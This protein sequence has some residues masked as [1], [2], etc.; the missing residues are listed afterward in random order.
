MEEATGA[1]RDLL[2][3]FLKRVQQTEPLGGIAKIEP[4][5]NGV[6][7]L[8]GI[9]RRFENDS[10]DDA[11]LFRG[12][13]R[14]GHEFRRI[15]DPVTRSATDARSTAEGIA[16]GK[17]LNLEVGSG[18]RVR[19]QSLQLP[20]QLIDLGGDLL[21]GRTASKMKQ[22]HS[23]LVV[24]EILRDVPQQREVVEV[25]RVQFKHARSLFRQRVIVLPTPDEARARSVAGTAMSRS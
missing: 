21:A 9:G 17:V 7:L 3:G 1:L 13:Q 14:Q 12:R 22:N 6:E 4:G 23:S 16:F 19:R 20:I 15:Q 25:R 11:S 10:S 8:F 24:V 18:L 2:S 5:E